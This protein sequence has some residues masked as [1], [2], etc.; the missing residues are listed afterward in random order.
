MHSSRE[1]YVSDDGLTRAFAHMSI[2]CNPGI[3]PKGVPAAVLRALPPDP[4][5]TRSRETTR[6]N[7]PAA[8]VLVQIGQTRT[9]NPANRFFLD[10]V[11]I[12]Y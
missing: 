4:D 5:I 12:L 11:H 10:T 1:M 9:T 6:G 7:V 3:I 2:R 8:A